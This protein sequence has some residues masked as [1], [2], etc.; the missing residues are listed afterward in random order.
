MQSKENNTESN[1]RVITTFNDDLY[2]NSGKAFLKT[3][4]RVMPEAELL[5]YEELEKGLKE[6]INSIKVTELPKFKEVFENHKDVISS[7]YGGNADRNS[8]TQKLAWEWQYRWFGWF[9]KIAAQHHAITVNKYK[10]Y[11]VF[12]DCDVRITKKF[13]KEYIRSKLNGKPMGVFK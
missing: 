7:Y 11:N 13:T 8:K 3:V 12:F 10:G 1:F 2:R 9:R 6:D 5:I 4:E